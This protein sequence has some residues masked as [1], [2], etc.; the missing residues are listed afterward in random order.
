MDPYPYLLQPGLQIVKDHAVPPV[1]ADDDVMIYPQPSNLNENNRA[2]QQAMI[3][4]TAPFMAQKGAPAA[5]VDVADAL[6][7]QDTT[8]FNKYYAGKPYSFPSQ[9]VECVLPL[10]TLPWD[11][12]SS[13]GEM[14]NAMF[15]RRYCKPRKQ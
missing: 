2:Y 1:C 4:G 14:Q 5:L 3:I 6:R 12:A 15:T 11:P 9:N 7:P 8:Q 10:R 13:R